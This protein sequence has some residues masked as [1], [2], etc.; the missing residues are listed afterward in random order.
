MVFSL[1]SGLTV[2]NTTAFAKQA[3]EHTQASVREAAVN[4]ILELYK[5][6]GSE[7]IGHLPTKDE[8][9]VKANKS[10][11]GKLFKGLSKFVVSQIKVSGWYFVLIHMWY[12]CD[13]HV[14]ISSSPCIR[15]FDFL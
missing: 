14:V 13:T 2:A 9:K 8:P 7:V 11:Y 15:C 10:L 3:M 4:L 6:K 5:V 1:S 12:A